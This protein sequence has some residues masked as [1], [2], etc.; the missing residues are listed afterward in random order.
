M[1]LRLRR[2]LAMVS[3]LKMFMDVFVGDRSKP[4]K[5]NKEIGAFP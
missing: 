2:Y 1:L 4:T 3:Q 5:T